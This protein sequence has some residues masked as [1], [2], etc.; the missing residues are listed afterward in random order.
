MEQT[1]SSVKLRGITKNIQNRNNIKVKAKGCSNHSQKQG[2][3]ESRVLTNEDYKMGLQLNNK[4]RI[5][6]TGEAKHKE[7][8]E[9]TTVVWKMKFEEFKAFV[10]LSARIFI[11]YMPKR[12]RTRSKVNKSKQEHW[13]IKLPFK[14]QTIINWS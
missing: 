14:S 13:S 12:K 10:F 5:V 11:K 8:L 1:N 4:S 3:T 9:L 7:P 2:R 6:R